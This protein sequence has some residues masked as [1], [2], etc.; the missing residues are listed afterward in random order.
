MLWPVG[1]ADVCQAGS[2]S[3]GVPTL[4]GSRERSAHLE[5]SALRRNDKAVICCSA[6]KAVT[7][8]PKST[9]ER[10]TSSRTAREF[11]APAWHRAS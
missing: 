8:E 10:R 1:A 4:V 11:G 9:P 6:C 3:N 5:L 7:A 2:S